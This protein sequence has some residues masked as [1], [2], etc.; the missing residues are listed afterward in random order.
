MET[1]T[2]RTLSIDLLIPAEYN[3]RREVKTTD[4]AYRK[5]KQ[6]LE[7]FGLVE[8]LIWNETTGRLVGGHLRLRILKELEYQEIPVSVV[9]LDEAREKALNVIL[10]NREAQG[11]FDPLKLNE[12]LRELEPLP[13]LSLT[14]FDPSDLSSFELQPTDSIQAEEATDGVEIVLKLSTEKYEEISTKLDALIREFD[15]EVHIKSG[16][17]R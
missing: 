10:N 11:R 16:S 14:G 12:L 5:L 7:Q 2:V 15:L 13:E 3:P 9:N 6:S 4:K 17:L 1:L 8:P